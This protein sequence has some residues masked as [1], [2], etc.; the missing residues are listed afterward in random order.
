M[1]GFIRPSVHRFIHPCVI[2]WRKGGALYAPSH[3]STTIHCD[4]AGYSIFSTR[5]PVYF[6]RGSQR[7][8]AAAGAA[9]RRG[10]GVVDGARSLGRQKRLGHGRDSRQNGNSSI[11]HLQGSQPQRRLHQRSATRIYLDWIR[12][13]KLRSKL[14]CPATDPGHH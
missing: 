12:L 9:R 1:R 10:D 3:P 11:L 2:V 14:S 13:L 6:W 8:N 7:G 4:P 5:P